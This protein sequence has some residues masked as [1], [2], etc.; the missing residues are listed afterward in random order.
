MPSESGVIENDWAIHQL[1]T[2]ANFARKSK[3]LS[4]Y[5][6]GLNFQIEHHL[7]P[8][9]PSSRLAAVQPIVRK[10]FDRN[11]IA[12]NGVSWPE[13]ICSIAVHLR[14]IGRAQ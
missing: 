2:T 8:Q 6:G 13:A 3:W 9:V 4:W 1:N 12:Y 14:K 7:F 11:A 10:H 5:V